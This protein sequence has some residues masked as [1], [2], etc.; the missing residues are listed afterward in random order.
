MRACLLSIIIV[1]AEVSVELFSISITISGFEGKKST[2][3][4]SKEKRARAHATAQSFNQHGDCPAT[5][6]RA[7]DLFLCIYFLRSVRALFR[8]LYRVF[9][10]GAFSLTS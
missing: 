7:G 8:Q 9:M 6:Q 3:V 10:T 1:T 2:I 5:K 4:A